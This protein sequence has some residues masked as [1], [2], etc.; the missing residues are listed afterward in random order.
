[1]RDLAPLFEHRLFL[2]ATPHNGHSNSFC[3]L[4]EILDPQRFCR[5]ATVEPKN[6]DAVMVRRLKDDLTGG[7]RHGFPK[8]AGRRVGLD[9]LPDEAPELALARLLDEYRE[10]RE[11]R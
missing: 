3:A 4:L 6:L 8:R 9:D 7:V 2:S 11:A 1:M 5:G 10:L